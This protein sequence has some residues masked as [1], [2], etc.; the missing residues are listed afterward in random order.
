MRR[1]LSSLGS[2]SLRFSNSVPGV[3]VIHLDL[4][5]DPVCYGA[6]MVDI[7]LQHCV[8]IGDCAFGVAER[9]GGSPFQEGRPEGL[10]QP[11]GDHTPQQPWEGQLQGA[12]EESPASR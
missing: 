4:P 1:A 6:V 12:G 11:P 3:D 2:R 8:D 5:K 9:C 10:F 7:P